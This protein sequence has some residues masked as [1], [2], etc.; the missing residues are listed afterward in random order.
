MNTGI[1]EHNLW[2]YEIEMFIKEI[3]QI[4]KWEKQAKMIK[5]HLIEE[6]QQQN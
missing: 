4:T 2:E 5:Q 6:N 3:V 1:S